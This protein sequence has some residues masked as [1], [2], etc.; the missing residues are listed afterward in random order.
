MRHFET[1]GHSYMG[2][3]AVRV[4]GKRPTPDYF[5]MLRDLQRA[6]VRFYSMVRGRQEKQGYR[7]ARWSWPSG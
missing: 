6:P 4:C 7:S 3:V 5:L 1:F 2:L